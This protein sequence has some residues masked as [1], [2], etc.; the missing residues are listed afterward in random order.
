MRAMLSRTFRRSL[1]EVVAGR[2]RSYSR[3]AAKANPAPV[4]RK[5]RT[6]FPP[7][8]RKPAETDGLPPR[9]IQLPKP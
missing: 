9:V 8:I 1:P 7:D 4:Y 3:E 2:A 5:S 6:A